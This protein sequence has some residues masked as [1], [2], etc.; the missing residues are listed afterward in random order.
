MEFAIGQ[1]K[2]RIEIINFFNLKRQVKV[3][4][5][6]TVGDKVVSGEMFISEQSST[7]IELRLNVKDGSN[8]KES[9]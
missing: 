7:P 3:F 4:I 5:N 6:G 2:V 1:V 8:A 9:A